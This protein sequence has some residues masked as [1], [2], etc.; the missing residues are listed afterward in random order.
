MYHNDLF[1]IDGLKM[2]IKELD[3]IVFLRILPYWRLIASMNKF[4][5]TALELVSHV[6]K[7][8]ILRLTKTC[9]S[10][11]NTSY[12]DMFAIN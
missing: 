7:S 6:L 4:R 11:F 3:L 1:L 12:P 5:L 2:H 8:S 10:F 9:A